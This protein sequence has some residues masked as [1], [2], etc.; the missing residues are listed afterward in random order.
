MQDCIVN[1]ITF[2]SSSGPVPNMPICGRSVGHRV[3]TRDFSEGPRKPRAAGPR[4]RN[5]LQLFWGIRGKGV[6]RLR[7]RDHVLKANMVC[8]YLPEDTHH[9]WSISPQWEFRWI[10]LDGRELNRIWKALNTRQSPRWAGPCPV[11]DFE[12]LR[13]ELSD[14]SPLAERVASATAMRILFQGTAPK[15][16]P[17]NAI[18]W[19]I[20]ELLQRHLVDL[21]FTIEDL[22]HKLKRNRSTLARTYRAARGLSISQ[23]LTRLRLQKAQ[24]LLTTT[25]LT[26]AEVAYQ[27]G[28]RDPDY[29]GRVFKRELGPTPRAFRTNG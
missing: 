17:A 2:R 24:S 29:F 12:Q 23:Q 3:V 16:P 27:C 28:Y 13:Q 9:F 5:I 19:R 8:I 7:G 6:V 21:D 26:I 4:P 10:T 14:A 20:D 11:S 18:V 22:A 25:T 1:Q 15:R